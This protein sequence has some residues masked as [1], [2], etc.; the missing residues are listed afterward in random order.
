MSVH[1]RKVPPP[2]LW[3]LVPGPF[4]GGLGNLYTKQVLAPPLNPGSAT[5]PPPPTPRPQDK[6][7][8]KPPDRS[9]L[10]IH[11]VVRP[12]EFLVKI[13]MC[14]CQCK[15]QQIATHHQNESTG[16]SKFLDLM[17]FFPENFIKS[18]IALEAFP[19]PS[20]GR[21][22]TEKPTTELLPPRNLLHF[23]FMPFLPPAYVVRREIMFLQGGIYTWPGPDGGYLPWS[24]GTPR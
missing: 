10:C 15:S 9:R 6:D 5:D 23:I 16:T 2:D 17:D 14:L 13:N 18:S 4:L 12:E 22:P 11:L 7:S 1:W 20:L 8:T 21:E 19:Y 3:I 24:G